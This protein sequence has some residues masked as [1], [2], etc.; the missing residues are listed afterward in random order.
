MYTAYNIA[1]K[2]GYRFLRRLMALPIPPADK[3]LPA[4]TRL[5]VQA[6]TEPLQ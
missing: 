4:F 1:D 6:T 2:G 3:I 5:R